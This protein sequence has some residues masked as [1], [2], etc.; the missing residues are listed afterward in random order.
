MMFCKSWQV[1]DV[2][3]SILLISFAA[4]AANDS[5]SVNTSSRTAPV[6]T[7]V[8][9]DRIIV[10]ATRTPKKQENV[11]AVVTVIGKEQ[12]EATPARTVGDLIGILPGI[13]ATEPQ[14]AGVVTPQSQTIRGNGFPGHAMILL[15]GQ[16]LNTPYTDYAYLTTVPIHAIDRIEVIRGAFSSLYG[17]SAGGGIVNII[18]KAGG[19]SSHVTLWGQIGDF[20]RYGAGLDLGIV[21]QRFSWGF[22]ADGKTED[23]Y[24]LYDDSSA[25]YNIA[26]DTANREYSHIRVHTKISSFLLEDKVHLSLSGGGILGSTGIGISEQLRSPVRKHQDMLNPYIN[27]FSTIKLNPKTELRGQLDWLK[28]D[29]TYYGETLERVNKTD[30]VND[31]QY[32][33]SINT[34]ESHRYRGDLSASMAV[35]PDQII[36]GGIEIMRSEASKVITDTSKGR[37]L[38]VQGRKGVAGTASENQGSGYLQYDGT[39]LNRFEIVLGGRYDYYDSYGSEYSPKATVRVRY[40]DKAGILDDGTFK[41]SVGKGF[42]APSLSELYS[43]PWSITTGMVYMG[44]PDLKAEQLLS[45]EW[46]IEQ[47]TMN[48]KMLLR[49]SP[50]YTKAND[51]IMSSPSVDPLNPHANLM[52]PVNV[53]G[54]TMKGIDLEASWKLFNMVTPYVNA[55]YN[56][57]IDDSTG[58]I[59]DGYAKYSGTTG[60]FLNRQVFQSIKLFGSYAVSYKGQYVSANLARSVIDTLGNFFVHNASI[61]VTYREFASVSYDIYNV[62]N[63]REKMAVEKR[64]PERNFLFEASI[65]VPLD[66]RWPWKE[67]RKQ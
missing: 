33:P 49:F 36:T 28:T 16:P 11:P 29:H 58:E 21:G 27:L 18:T 53:R 5:T 9:L 62:L 66:G 42:R 25:V 17:S 22:F 43:P 50:Y 20:G 46:S 55:N 24:Y 19:T 54:V 51:F 23:N 4:V 1:I 2:F 38:D 39:F 32:V 63:N 13:S 34:T 15:D 67:N 48:K 59:I 47:R 60:I 57:T 10:T 65:R 7:I 40:L 56:A 37:I 30:G 26:K 8:E 3:S 31:P 35:T 45:F 6:D 44:N 41:F 52:I 64:L 61:G 12:I 14:G